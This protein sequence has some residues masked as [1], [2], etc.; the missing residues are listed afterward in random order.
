M[1]L[2]YVMIQEELIL[3]SFFFFV[4]T[5]LGQTTG[6]LSL[7]KNMYI[8]FTNIYWL[9]IKGKIKKFWL[10]MLYANN[11]NKLTLQT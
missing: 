6:I 2:A 7:V 10:S 5:Q 3:F 11:Q 9:I 1:F 4:P 8:Y